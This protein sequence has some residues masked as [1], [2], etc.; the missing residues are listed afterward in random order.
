[1]TNTKPHTTTKDTSFF[2]LVKEN[3]KKLKLLNESARMSKRL[4]NGKKATLG[5]ITINH[6]YV[7]N[8]DDD[9]TCYYILDFYSPNEIPEIFD[10]TQENP[11]YRAEF[12]DC[13]VIVQERKKVMIGVG[14]RYCIRAICKDASFE[15]ILEDKVCVECGKPIHKFSAYKNFVATLGKS[16]HAFRQFWKCEYVGIKCCRCFDDTFN[17]SF[18]TVSYDYYMSDSIPNSVVEISFNEY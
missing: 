8:E 3:T 12:K 13:R 2:S 7:V 14:I 18:N 9:V 4:L 11:F 17:Q 6:S 15:K 1:M 5:R 10:V 16:I